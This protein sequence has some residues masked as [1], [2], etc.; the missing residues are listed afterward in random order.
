MVLMA[1]KT[2]VFF[3]ESRLPNLEKHQ[4]TSR[5]RAV[6]HLAPR[7]QAHK[8]RLALPKSTPDITKSELITRRLRQAV[9]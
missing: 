3:Q 6:G 7:R 4:A 2:A 8:P 5:N 9:Q 1:K